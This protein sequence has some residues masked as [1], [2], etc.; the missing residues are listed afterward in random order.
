[1][2]VVTRKVDDFAATGVTALNPWKALGS[3]TRHRRADVGQ[4]LSGLQQFAFA[5]TRAFL[6]A[7]LARID[8]GGARAAV[9]IQPF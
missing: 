4:S 5:G 1:M 8:S 7:R 3:S 6:S 2:T 9:F